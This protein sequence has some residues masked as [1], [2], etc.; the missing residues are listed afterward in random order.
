MCSINGKCLV[1]KAVS[2]S[3]NKRVTNLSRY[4]GRGQRY[5]IFS[6]CQMTFVNFLMPL[7]YNMYKKVI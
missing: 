6:L 4:A 1:K 5:E 7:S 2:F 3:G